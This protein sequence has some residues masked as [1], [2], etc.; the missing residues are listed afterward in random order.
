[1]NIAV[2]LK[3]GT[4]FMMTGVQIESVEAFERTIMKHA[5]ETDEPVDFA[6][7]KIQPEDI[8]TFVEIDEE[9]AAEFIKQ[10]RGEDQ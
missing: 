8:L 7:I 3:D 6:G 1:M 5:M 9:T 2:I 4:A 10:S